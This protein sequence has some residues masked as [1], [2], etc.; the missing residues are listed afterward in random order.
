M[1]VILACTYPCG[2]DCQIAQWT[3]KLC[4]LKIVPP[5]AKVRK[6]NNDGISA[7]Y[8]R[9]SCLCSAMLYPSGRRLCCSF[10]WAMSILCSSSM[11]LLTQ[12]KLTVWD[13]TPQINCV[14]NPHKMVRY[15]GRVYIVPL[16]RVRW[17]RLH[18]LHD[19][20][21]WIFCWMVQ[22]TFCRAP[23]IA[24]VVRQ[25][26]LHILCALGLTLALLLVCHSYS[27]VKLN[28]ICTVQHTL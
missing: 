5:T 21:A 4:R 26:Y 6:W 14:L 3:V 23:T 7:T 2:K 12:W 17:Q 11:I 16:A 20:V 24:C 8:H 13:G 22:G 1:S 15:H 10:A 28:V 25:P 19:V 9:C 27:L 18:N